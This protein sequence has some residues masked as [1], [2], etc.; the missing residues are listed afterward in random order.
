MSL[1]PLPAFLL[2]LCLLP[3]AT[4]QA[5][6]GTEVFASGGAEIP[7][8]TAGVKIRTGCEYEAGI[9][10]GIGPDLWT[11]SARLNI[12]SPNPEPDKHA[13]W[14]GGPEFA[15]YHEDSENGHFRLGFVNLMMGREHRWTEHFR[16]AYEWGLGLMVLSE[17]HGGGAP[18]LF[19]VL[20]QARA[21]VLYRL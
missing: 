8:A 5:C 13:T 18:I 4:A 10:A 19:P 3:L 11:M 21:E 14:F 12:F 7:A 20:P 6:E 1:R 16:F 2:A 15:Y 9:R 17:Y